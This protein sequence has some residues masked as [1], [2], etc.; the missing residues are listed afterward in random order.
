MQ[1]LQRTLKG[2]FTFVQSYFPLV[3]TYRFY[4]RITFVTPARLHVAWFLVFRAR[5][6]CIYFQFSSFHGRICMCNQMVTREIW[7]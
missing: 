1:S 2:E 3:S 4:L 5:I 7:E 6:Y